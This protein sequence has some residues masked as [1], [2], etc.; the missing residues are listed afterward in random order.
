MPEVRF[1]QQDDLPSLYQFAI[2]NAWELLPA[3]D[4]RHASAAHVERAAV[5]NLLTMLS[6]PGGTALV[7]VEQGRPV[8]YLLLG[9]SPE[10]QPGG[11]SAYMADIYIEPPFRGLGLAA[12]FN[13]VAEQYLTQLGVRTASRWMHAHN[14]HSQKVA[15]RQGYRIVNVVMAKTLR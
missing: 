12:R 8:G 3:D 14:E 4:Q 7:A 5:A 9:V 13:E 11:R 2:R 6:L 1:W 15:Q 10:G